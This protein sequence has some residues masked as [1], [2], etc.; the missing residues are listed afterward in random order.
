MAVGTYFV[1]V[2]VT[3][4]DAGSDDALISFEVNCDGTGVVGAGNLV[5]FLSCFDGP[6]EGRGTQCECTDLDS[7][8]DVTMADFAKL[9]RNYTGN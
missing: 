8:G 1:R 7:D 9:Q 5:S 4:D 6:N 2:T 3:D